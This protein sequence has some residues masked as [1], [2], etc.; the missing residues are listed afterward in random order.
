[1][2]T[3]FVY[4]KIKTNNKNTMIGTNFQ[5]NFIKKK[6]ADTRSKEVINKMGQYFID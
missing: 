2:Y 1:M 6:P 5:S 4:F 3:S